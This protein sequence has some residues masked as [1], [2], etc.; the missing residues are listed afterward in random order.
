MS[1][2]N[3][4]I[5]KRDVDAWNGDDFDSWFDL[6]DADV[7]WFALME[8]YRGHSGVRQAWESFKTD[9][10]IM[11]RFGDIRDLGESVLALGELKGT[12]R[13]TEM[14]VAGE[15]A[16]LVTHRN[17]KATSVRDFHSHAEAFKVAGLSE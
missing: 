14:N 7:E 15:L 3:V 5:F 16:Q 6:Y 11:V 1:R 10:G 4:E 17:R 8:V 9:A 12:G 2:E 13:R